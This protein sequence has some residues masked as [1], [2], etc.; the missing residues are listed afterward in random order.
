MFD[1]IGCYGWLYKLGYWLQNWKSQKFKFLY[2]QKYS[3]D[4]RLTVTD[5]V[6]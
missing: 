1:N 6:L 3:S 4:I 2:I 5:K